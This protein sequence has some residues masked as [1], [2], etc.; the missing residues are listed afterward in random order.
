[1]ASQTV[2][3]RISKVLRPS[4]KCVGFFYTTRASVQHAA[5]RFPN[6]DSHAPENAVL[7]TITDFYER[8]EGACAGP[9]AGLAH[10]IAR[11]RRCRFFLHSA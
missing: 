2:R 4:P 6:V 1:M 9:K 5:R 3:E 8:P 10:H 7:P 11:L